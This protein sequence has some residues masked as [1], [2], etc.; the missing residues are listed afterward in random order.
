[1]PR[2]KSILDNSGSSESDNEE[3]KTDAVFSFLEPLLIERDTDVDAFVSIRVA[4]PG[5][6]DFTCNWKVLDPNLSCI[7]TA[8]LSGIIHAN[9]DVI[10]IFFKND[11]KGGLH[12]IDILLHKN[13]T[14]TSLGDKKLPKY[15]S[16]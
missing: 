16:S 5:D 13:S 14:G 1:M 15:I 12:N 8:S 10:T 9:D 4:T 7:G 6:P 2:C 3:F 11:S